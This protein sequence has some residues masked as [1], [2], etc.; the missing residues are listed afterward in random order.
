MDSCD[1]MICDDNNLMESVFFLFD[2]LR[3]SHFLGAHGI[4]QNNLF[5]GKHPL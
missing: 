4:F 2:G 3:V 1:H 5:S